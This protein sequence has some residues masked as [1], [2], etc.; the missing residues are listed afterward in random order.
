MRA[1]RTF[2]EAQK[3]EPKMLQGRI[4]QHESNLALRVKN[5]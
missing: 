5:K 3:A 1:P 4:Y 2:S